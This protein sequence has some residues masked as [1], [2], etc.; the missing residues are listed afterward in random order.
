MYVNDL[1]LDLG[2]RGRRALA[3]LL[4]AEPEVV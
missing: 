2:Q 1:T 3:L 4:D